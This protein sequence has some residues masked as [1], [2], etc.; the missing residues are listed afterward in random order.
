M[1]ERKALR[2][3]ATAVAFTVVVVG[4]GVGACGDDPDGWGGSG[5]TTSTGHTA[6]DPACMSPCPTAESVNATGTVDGTTLTITFSA[7]QMSICFDSWVDQPTVVVASELGT[8]VDATTDDQ[9]D[10][11]IVIELADPLTAGTVSVDL[12]FRIEVAMDCSSST[13]ESCQLSRVF[14]VSFSNTGEPEIALREDAPEPVLEHRPPMRLSFVEAEGTQ[15]TVRVQGVPAD[16]PFRFEVTGGAVRVDG[17]TAVW[18][19]PERPGWYQIEAVAEQGGLLATDA[20]IVEVR[21][22]SQRG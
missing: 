18:Q 3:A 9:G 22:T 4:A 20:L 17:A 19:L 5:T 11:T 6:C 13:T 12:G 21:P 16:L 15:A 10:V 2:P 7:T 1:D 14:D 8:L